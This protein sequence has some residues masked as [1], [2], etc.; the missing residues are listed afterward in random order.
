VGQA[1]QQRQ[2]VDCRGKPPGGQGLEQYGDLRH[3]SIHIGGPMVRLLPQ[4]ALHESFN[5]GRDRGAVISNLGRRLVDMSNE[6]LDGLPDK[7]RPTRQYLEQD[8]TERVDVCAVI[9]PP[10]IVVLLG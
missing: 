9:D 5:R 7:G 10:R 2:S 8:A 6:R 3:N 1:P 4:H